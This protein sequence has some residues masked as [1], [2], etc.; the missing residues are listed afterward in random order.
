MKS[1]LQIHSGDETLILTLTE[2]I[3]PDVQVASVRVEER[4]K[5]NNT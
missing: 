4:I 5:G 1:E 2:Y 3:S